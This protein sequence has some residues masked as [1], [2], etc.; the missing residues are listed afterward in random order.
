MFLLPSTGCSLL[1]F[2]VDLLVGVEGGRT[3]KRFLFANI[4]FW[5]SSMIEQ[6]RQVQE[7]KSI[8]LVVVA[9]FQDYYINTF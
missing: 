4:S 6:S 7:L 5:I 3:G 8:L 9:G 2:L 1:W